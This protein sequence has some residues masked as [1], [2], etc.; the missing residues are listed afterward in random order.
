MSAL[1]DVGLDAPVEQN[2]A[3]NG[4]GSVLDAIKAK[5]ATI[6][7]QHEYEM[8]LPRYGD[9]L[10][11]VCK[12]LPP[13]IQTR[14]AERLQQRKRDSA[15]SWTIAADILVSVCV[16]VRGRVRPT[17]PLQDLDPDEPVR[18][19]ERLAELLSIEATKARDV[20]LALFHGAPSPGLALDAAVGEYLAWAG[21]SDAEVD[22]E[23]LGE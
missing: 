5:R 7:A 12:P 19:D 15:A 8:F 3:T 4:A 11:L 10:V 2:G 6:A 21:G 16:A 20:A 14:L 1:D 9:Q 17:G 22:E 13:A 23:L 18:I